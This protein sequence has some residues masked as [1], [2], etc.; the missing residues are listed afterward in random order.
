V[1][2]PGDAASLQV[3]GFDRPPHEELSLL[4]G[5]TDLSRQPQGQRDLDERERHERDREDREERPPELLRA[6]GDRV[7]WDRGLEE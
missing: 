7:S 1:Q 3:R 4:L 2:I 5:G 6:R